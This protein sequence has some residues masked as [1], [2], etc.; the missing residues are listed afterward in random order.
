MLLNLQ[1]YLPFADGRFFVSALYTFLQS[2]NSSHFGAA[3]STLGDSKYL[4]AG[5]FGDFAGGSVRLGLETTYTRQ[6]FNNDTWRSNNGGQFS[7]WYIF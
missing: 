6:A 2:D 4:S 7:M 3:A 5:I 1:Y